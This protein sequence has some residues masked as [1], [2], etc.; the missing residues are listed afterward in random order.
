[1]SN[2]RMNFEYEI[3]IKIYDIDIINSSFKLKSLNNKVRK[4]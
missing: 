1:M 2:C 4:Y 3:F